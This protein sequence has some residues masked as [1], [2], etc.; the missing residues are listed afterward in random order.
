M[1]EKNP[2]PAGADARKDVNPLSS[3]VKLH[4][5]EAYLVVESRLIHQLVREVNERVKSGW[6]CQ[7]GLAVMSRP[8]E[9]V[10]YFQA[11]AKAPRAGLDG[12]PEAY[13]TS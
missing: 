3:A 11:L 13:F 2:S 9:P 4:P 6:V 5:G 7:G 8:N 12:Q 10:L 1:S